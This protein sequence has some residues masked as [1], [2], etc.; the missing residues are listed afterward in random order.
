MLNQ[1]HL[2]ARLQTPPGPAWYRRQ[3]AQDKTAVI[4]LH[5]LPNISEVLRMADASRPFTES[6]PDGDV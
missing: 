2:P 3:L 1:Q 6:R 5:T 4:R